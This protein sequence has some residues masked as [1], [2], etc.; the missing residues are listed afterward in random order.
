MKLSR[1]ELGAVGLVAAGLAW[2]CFGSGN[3]RIQ[4]SVTGSED[5]QQYNPTPGG[6]P[7]EFVQWAPVSWAGRTRGYPG[8]AG[9]GITT[10]IYRGP[11]DWADEG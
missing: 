3:R 10:L 11:P 6:L 1:G 4:V 9:A 5:V 8:A 2:A 7:S